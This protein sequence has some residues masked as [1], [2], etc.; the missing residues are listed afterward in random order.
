MK[1]ILISVAGLSPQ[2][3]TETL[4]ALGQEG[5][6]DFPAELHIVTTGVGARRIR[7][8]LLGDDG[9]LARLSRE[10]GCAAPDVV[11]H[12][13]RATDG[14]VLDDVRTVADNARMADMIATVV[15]DLR[16]R[17]DV[18]LHASLAGGRKSMS[19]YMGYALSLFG[20]PGDRLSHVL[21]TPAFESCPDFWYPP[22]VPQI[23]RGRAGN[24]LDT[25]EARV[26]LADIP[27]L[28]L[29]GR[30]DEPHLAAPVIDF[31][32]TVE[33]LRRHLDRPVLEVD[34]ATLELRLGDLKLRLPPREFAIYLTLAEARTG[35]LGGIGCDGWVTAAEWRDIGQAAPARMLEIYDN[36]PRR[37]RDD[38]ADLRAY[39]QDLHDENNLWAVMAKA[40]ANIGKALKEA[41]AES[42]VWRSAGIDQTRRSKRTATARRLLTEPDRIRLRPLAQ[43]AM[44]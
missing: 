19:F 39:C 1:T 5:R 6:R 30:L 37:R 12:L 3:V 42:S 41:S 21:V 32:K 7:E 36:L 29:G 40:T 10:C 31:A 33:D 35:R 27:F 38:G 44:E 14:A 2:V 24:P 25:A 13:C 22:A 15:R 16:S 4:W 43:I 8:T 26:E 34:P 9:V 11:L 20:R 23:L 18:R 17:P 28:P